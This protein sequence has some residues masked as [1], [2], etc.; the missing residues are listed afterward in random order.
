MCDSPASDDVTTN[1]DVLHS[2]MP[3]YVTGME[4]FLRTTDH[5][6]IANHNK[7]CAISYIICTFKGNTEVLRGQGIANLAHQHHLVWSIT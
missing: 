7:L 5:H 6:H 1:Y 2:M 4:C 3:I